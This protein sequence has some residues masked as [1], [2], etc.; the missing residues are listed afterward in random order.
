MFYMSIAVTAYFFVRESVC[1][2]SFPHPSSRNTTNRLYPYIRP[3]CTLACNTFAASE[4]NPLNILH[5]FK[6]LRIEVF[7]SNEMR[8]RNLHFTYV[9]P[10][11][12]V[13]PGLF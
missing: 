4:L 9:R 12:S 2:L 1:L 10:T 13:I 8:F 11:Y 7:F 5:H 3:T 6:I